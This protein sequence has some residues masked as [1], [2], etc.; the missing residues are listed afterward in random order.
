[1]IQAIERIVKACIV[2]KNPSVAAAALVSSYHMFDLS[3]DIVRRWAPEVQ[4]AIHSKSVSGGF[5]STASG[6]LSSF[7]SSS[8]QSQ[9]IQSNSHIVQYHGL[10]LLYLIRQHDRVAIAK[11]VQAF[12]STSDQ[13]GVL[14]NPAAI[15][16]LI[17][18]ACKVLEDDSG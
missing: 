1:M 13:N 15:C 14:K 2:D 11:L 10:G 6:F 9:M 5:A 12:S 3:K 7:G 4:E 16:I 17:R 8:S 18:C